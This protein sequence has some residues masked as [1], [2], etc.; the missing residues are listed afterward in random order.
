M[1][2]CSLCVSV[3]L[4][5]F[6]SSRRRVKRLKEREWRTTLFLFYLNFSEAFHSSR[7]RVESGEPRENQNSNNSKNQGFPDSSRG[8]VPLTPLL[9][10]SER[11]SRNS[12][13]TLH[14][15]LRSPYP[16]LSLSFSSTRMEIFKTKAKNLFYNTVF[17]LP[18]CE[19]KCSFQ[20]YGKHCSLCVYVLCDCPVEPARVETER[21]WRTNRETR[22][23]WFREMYRRV[24]PGLCFVRA[25]V[26]PLY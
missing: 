4:W 10:I 22:L 9:E 21:E 17:S 19:G 20:K 24:S 2:K 8:R 26:P 6:H 18:G 5:G 7:R 11:I 14:Y 13:Y 25:L 23:F 3:S 16:L 1:E 12:L 15:S